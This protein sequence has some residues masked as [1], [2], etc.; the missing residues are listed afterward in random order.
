MTARY[1]QPFNYV[2][3]R[4]FAVALLHDCAVASALPVHPASTLFD[5]SLNE[6]LAYDLDK[7]KKMFDDLK[8]VDYDGD[9]EREYMPD[10]SSPLDISL[11]LIVYAD[12]TFKVSMANKIAADLTSIGIP[13]K[14]REMSWDNYQAGAQGRQI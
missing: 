9:G 8:I 5:S 11:S 4:A 2:V 10:G 7:A 12:S 1:R 3:D 14:V 13:V 6:S